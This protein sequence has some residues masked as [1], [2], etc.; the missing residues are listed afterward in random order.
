MN[1]TCTVCGSSN[2]GQKEFITIK[3]NIYAGPQCGLL[4]HISDNEKQ[5]VELHYCAS[6]FTKEVKDVIRIY[7]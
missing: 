5:K 1:N 4:K 6:C 3:A 7:N 2:E